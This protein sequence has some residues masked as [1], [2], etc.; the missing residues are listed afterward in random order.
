MDLDCSNNKLKSLD[1]TNNKDLKELNCSYNE[2]T[3]LNVTRENNSLKSVICDNNKLSASAFQTVL[4]VYGDSNCSIYVQDLAS[5]T[6]QNEFNTS[7]LA[8]AKSNNWTPY[9][10]DADRIPHEYDENPIATS[11]DAATAQEDTTDGD[12]P[13][14]NLQGQHVGKDYRGVV[15]VNGRKVQVKQKDEQATF[16]QF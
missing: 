9:Y 4:S 14:Y 13:R 11:I 12:A 1:V 10:Y 5:S 3:S 6:E 2:L 15:I 7:L 8:L 16:K